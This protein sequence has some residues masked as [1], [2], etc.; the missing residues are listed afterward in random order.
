MRLLNEPLK[1]ATQRAV[2]DLR[3]DGGEGGVIAVDREGHG[4]FSM[5]NGVGWISF[6]NPV[7]MPL[8]CGG[9]YRG[10]IR[11]DGVAKTAIFADDVL[12]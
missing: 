2:D 11:K 12:S 3:R 10:V 6:R 5:L 7:A 9:M 1:K 4:E 8:N